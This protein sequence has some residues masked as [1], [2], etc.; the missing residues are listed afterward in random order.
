LIYSLAFSVILIA[1]GIR[2][3][4]TDSWLPALLL[5]LLGIGVGFRGIRRRTRTERAASRYDY[6]RAD[7]WAELD[8]GK[9]P[10]LRPP[11]EEEDRENS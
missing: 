2:L 7:T 5:L 8:R 4:I 10:T 1:S 6:R 3:A 11:V 9:D